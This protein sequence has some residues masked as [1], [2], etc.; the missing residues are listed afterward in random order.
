MVPIGTGFCITVLA[1]CISERSDVY[2]TI[3]QCSTPSQVELGR[4]ASEVA[5][6]KALCGR[7]ASPE[8]MS[9]NDLLSGNI[10]VLQVG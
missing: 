8:I 5:E 1:A 3:T 6:V 4:L 2:Y 10:L 7:V 9:H